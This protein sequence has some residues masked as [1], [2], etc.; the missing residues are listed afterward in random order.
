MTLGTM[1]L[2]MPTPLLMT[3]GTLKPAQTTLS[4]QH[5]AYNT[6]HITLGITTL[7]KTTVSKMTLN[8]KLKKNF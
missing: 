5:S 8:F 1:A 4:I 6:Q 2:G 7:N 3:L